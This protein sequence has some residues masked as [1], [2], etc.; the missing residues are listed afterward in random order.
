VAVE[1]INSNL[2]LIAE[3]A[4]DTVILTEI[5]SVSSEPLNNV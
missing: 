5:I 3:V 2:M 1:E 4:G